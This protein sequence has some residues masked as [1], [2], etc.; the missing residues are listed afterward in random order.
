[1]QASW[2]KVQQLFKELAQDKNKPADFQKEVED[3]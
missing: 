1:M 2:Q 3:E